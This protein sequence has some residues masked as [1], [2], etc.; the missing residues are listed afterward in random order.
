MFL[1]LLI[2]AFMPSSTEVRKVPELLSVMAA[3]S[4]VSGE[5]V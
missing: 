1:G 4:G 5:W 2:M 3:K